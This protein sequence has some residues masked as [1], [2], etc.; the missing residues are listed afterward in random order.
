[1]KRIVIP[2]L[3]SLFCLG[4]SQA[5]AQSCSGGKS[6]SGRSGRSSSSSSHSDEKNKDATPDSE[7]FDPNHMG[8]LTPEKH[9]VLR[10]GYGV[11]AIVGMNQNQVNT[12]RF[13]DLSWFNDHVAHVFD[14]S[15]SLGVSQKWGLGVSFAYQKLGDFAFSRTYQPEDYLGPGSQ[16]TK[17]TPLTAAWG[18]KA[19]TY[20]PSLYAEYNFLKMGAHFNG[21]VRADLGMTVYRA[22]MD[23]HYQDTCGCSKM[24]VSD[25]EMASSLNV[26]LGIGFRWEYEFIGLKALVS[27]QAQTKVNFRDADTY[28][29]YSFDFDA[30]HYN[31]DGRPAANKFTIVKSGDQ[32]LA[33]YDPLYIQF[34][35]YFRLGSNR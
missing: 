1:M 32:G 3:I 6:S 4:F 35:L 30:A 5:Y 15:G 16:Q 25:W 24:V 11:N 7:R 12:M 34:M 20:T 22:Y 2:A 14:F 18:L 17:T 26:G 28:S 21:F 27:Y 31:F 9:G 19:R 8:N 33:K 13:R 29:N 23:V 10:F